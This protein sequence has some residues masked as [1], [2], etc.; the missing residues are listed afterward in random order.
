MS[1]NANTEYY[2]NYGVVGSESAAKKALS[3]DSGDRFTS[4]SSKSNANGVELTVIDND[5]DGVADYVLWLQETLSQVIAKND[6]KETTTLS[7]LNSNKAIDNEDIVTDLTMSESDL[8]LAVSYGGRYYVSAPEVVTGQMESFSSSKEKQQYIEVNGT[9]YNPSFIVYEADSADNTYE[10][11]VLDCG[12]EDGVDFDI[13]YDFILDSNGNVIAYRPSEQGL[14]DYAL[15]L[16]SGYDP[17]RTTDSANGEVKVLLPDG[18]EG[19]YELNWSASA[20]NIGDQLYPTLTSSQRKDN[21]VE[22]LKSFLGTSVHDNT[23]S[24]PDGVLKSGATD[25][26]WDSVRGSVNASGH[27]AGYVVGYSLN[28]DN[29]LTITSIVGSNNT[30]AGHYSPTAATEDPHSTAGTLSKSYNS[31]A[32]RVEYN[33]GRNEL[34]IDKNTVAFYYTT[35]SKGDTVYGVAVGYNNMSD[36]NYNDAA[37]NSF[38]ASTVR[39]TTLASSV[40]FNAEGVL[41]EKN[42][43]YV[44]STSRTDPNYVTLNVIL[45]DGTASTLKIERSDWDNLFSGKPEAFNTVYSYTLKNDVATLTPGTNDKA[46]EIGYAKQLRSGTVAF[47]EKNSDGTVGKYLGAYSYENNIWNVEDISAGTNAPKGAFAQNVY[48]EAILVLDSK[49]DTVRAAYIKSVYDGVVTDPGHDFNWVL[50][51]YKTMYPDATA[52]EIMDA[53][54]DGYNVRIV[55]DYTLTNNIYLRDGKILYVTGNLTSSAVGR[56]SGDG[57][58]WVGGHY[59][60][61]SG[62]VTVDTQVAGNVT[63][64]TTATT[65]YGDLAVE[66]GAINMNGQ[67]LTIETGSSVYAN[68]DVVN[69]STAA[70]LT[71]KGTLEANNYNLSGNAIEVLSANTLIAR[72]NVTAATLTIGSSSAAGRAQ[73]TGTVTANVTMN[74]GSLNAQSVSGTITRNG[75]T[76]ILSGDNTST[77]LG[78]KASGTYAGDVSLAAGATVAA[79]ETLTVD[80]DLT[81]TDGTVTVSGT[82]ELNGSADVNKLAGAAGGKVVFGNSFKATGSTANFVNSN[83]DVLSNDQLAGRTFTYNTTSNKFVTTSVLTDTAEITKVELTAP[84]GDS[85]YTIKQDTQ[86]V[87]VTI[88]DSV[89]E[90][91]ITVTPAGTGTIAEATDKDNKVS[92]SDKVITVDT[93]ALTKAGD[94]YSFTIKVSETGKN[95]STYTFNIKVVEDKA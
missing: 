86:V 24:E 67:N 9:Q 63:F 1:V 20:Q 48:K 55:G 36:V 54:D 47:Y 27:A 75:G 83:G 90:V 21:G 5:Q 72:G 71:V 60:E 43:A 66:N 6:T 13:D 95:S 85:D 2:V 17:G 34:I 50:T 22:T 87:D 42:Y 80:G 58:L 69:S 38:V 88:T 65:I 35:D 31:G 19:T 78:G 32:A 40:L 46:T 82:L 33:N 56:V 18:T 44:L 12:T 41:A 45:M 53:M 57:T 79:G 49:E 92:V 25:H 29:V 73:I 64:G 68:G 94:A 74:N 11:D 37:H 76:V 26:Y 61:T 62:Y 84:T 4:V 81:V 3:F 91:K 8:V 70:T 7:G 28:S 30:G 14:Y 10:F 59:T 39:D 23:T 15:I 77:N 89:N 51:N 93:T 52:T 16:D